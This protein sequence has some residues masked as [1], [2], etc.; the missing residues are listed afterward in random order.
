MSSS[1]TDWGTVATGESGDIDLERAWLRDAQ[2]A[3]LSRMPKVI[4]E[5]YKVFCKKQADYGPQNIA[6]AGP[7][8][9]TVRMVDK[10]SRLW[11]LLGLGT[12]D[13]H[14]PAN[15]EEALRDTAMDLA[16]Y[17]II[18][19]MTLDGSWKL[20]DIEDA[21]TVPLKTDTPQLSLFNDTITTE[22]IGGDD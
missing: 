20:M 22:R 17:G 19:M 21:F 7:K 9:V 11:N 3:Y 14:A 12:K 4:M 15:A 13:A 10:F 1:I 8:G 18:L 6:L 2:S 5:I 16:D